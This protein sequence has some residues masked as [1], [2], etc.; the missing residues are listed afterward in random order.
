MHSAFENTAPQHTLKFIFL[1]GNIILFQ[2]PTFEYTLTAELVYS[3][4][5][6]I[7]C[8]PKVT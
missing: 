7:Y 6:R 4:Y 3:L 8:V 5:K 1:C 2:S